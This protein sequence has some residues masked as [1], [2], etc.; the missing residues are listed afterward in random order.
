MA[1]RNVERS[2]AQARKDSGPV[3][4]RVR[5]AEA[6]AE[7]ADAQL[8]SAKEAAAAAEREV[9]S[10]KSAVRCGHI[11]QLAWVVWVLAPSWSTACCCN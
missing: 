9:Q 6:S 10:A 4:E 8:R 7:A 11:W 3:L 1:R 5:A 2:A